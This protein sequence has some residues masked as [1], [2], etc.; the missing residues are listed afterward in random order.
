MAVHRHA[1]GGVH[2]GVQSQPLLCYSRPRPG[3]HRPRGSGATE[4]AMMVPTPQL[5]LGRGQPV[6]ALGVAVHRTGGGGAPRGSTSSCS[7]P[8]LIPLQMCQHHNCFVVKKTPQV[9]HHHV[10]VC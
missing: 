2:S 3:G 7:S 1:L 10:Q 5:L 6:T 9:F 4:Q 8:P